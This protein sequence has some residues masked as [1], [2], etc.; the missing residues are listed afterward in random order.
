MHKFQ[1]IADELTTLIDKRLLRFGDRVPS[2]RS[3]AHKHHVSLGTAIHA[4]RDLEA[5]GLIES[6]ARSG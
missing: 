2:V 3:A 5:R 1:E 4:Y 6:R